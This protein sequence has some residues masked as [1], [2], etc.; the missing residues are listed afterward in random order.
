MKKLIIIITCLSVF[1]SYARNYNPIIVQDEEIVTECFGVWLFVYNNALAAGA[2][3]YDATV[4]A[5]AAMTTCA[6]NEQQ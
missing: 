3:H 6:E 5:T 1:S 4:L 2:S